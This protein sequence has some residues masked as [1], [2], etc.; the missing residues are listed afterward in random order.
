MM[1]LYLDLMGV[2][3]RVNY[4]LVSGE[5]GSATSTICSVVVPVVGPLLMKRV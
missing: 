3:L 5:V 2:V 4:F 1:I